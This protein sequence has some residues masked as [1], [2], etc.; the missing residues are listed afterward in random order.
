MYAD[1]DN[2]KEPSLPLRFHFVGLGKRPA[3]KQNSPTFRG[4][5][6]GHV[7]H[8]GRAVKKRSLGYLFWIST[9]ASWS[10]L[11][12]SV[13]TVNGKPVMFVWVFVCVK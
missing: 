8:G 10:R 13:Y 11:P 6:Y 9:D 12:V 4:Y 1:T 7:K 2:T 5:L 3:K